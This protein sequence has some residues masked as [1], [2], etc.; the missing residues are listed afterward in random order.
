M[1]ESHGD[2]KKYLDKLFGQW[3]ESE[4]GITVVQEEGEWR[5]TVIL[6][7]LWYGPIGAVVG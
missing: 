7:F 2:P 3:G 4:T 6:A 1:K 5:A